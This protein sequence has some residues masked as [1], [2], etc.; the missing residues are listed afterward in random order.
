MSVGAGE[1]LRIAALA[2]LRLTPEEVKRLS[3]ELSDI[4]GHMA[5]LGE[6]D[7]SG[8]EAAPATTWPARLRPDLPGAVPLAL[9]PARLAPEWEDGFFT[10]P[11]LGAMEAPPAP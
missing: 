2:R 1:V 3:S 5:V 7:T 4:L 9:P 10:L 8:V 11:R 6:A